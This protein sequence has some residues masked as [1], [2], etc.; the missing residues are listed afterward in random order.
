MEK[1]ME[2]ANCDFQRTVYEIKNHD[3]KYYKNKI[4][5][6]LP[7]RYF[8]SL[9]EKAERFLKKESYSE[10]FNCYRTLIDNYGDQYEKFING[11]K[12]FKTDFYIAL[13]SIE[14]R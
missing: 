11:K 5:N 14:E 1:L 4:L 6:N 7:P 12:Y 13:S 10:A 3:L 9:E 2:C 8:E